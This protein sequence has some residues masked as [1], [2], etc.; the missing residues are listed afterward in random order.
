[1]YLAN[2]FCGQYSLDDVR[3][4]LTCFGDCLPAQA[5]EFSRGAWDTHDL[6]VR[7]IIPHYHPFKR[8]FTEVEC[9]FCDRGSLDRL[10]LEQLAL[11]QL[12]WSTANYAPPQERALW[13][14][15]VAMYDQV[16]G[17]NLK[18]PM[19][20]QADEAFWVWIGGHF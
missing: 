19:Q 15:L 17:S 14:G 8:Q 16:C 10:G 11:G 1:M 7:K 13:D 12:H 9:G 2:V 3:T 20:Q 6:F 18:T 5:V 4:A